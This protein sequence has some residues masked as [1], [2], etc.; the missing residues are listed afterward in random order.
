[1]MTSKMKIM[2]WNLGLGGDRGFKGPILSLMFGACSVG[3][4]LRLSGQASGSGFQDLV[5]KMS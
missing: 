5:L 2:R 4:G 3:Q 1:M